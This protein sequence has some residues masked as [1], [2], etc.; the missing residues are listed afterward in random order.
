[1]KLCPD[2]KRTATGYFWLDW[3]TAPYWRWV[4]ART[5]RKFHR[6]MG[7]GDE[8]AGKRLVDEA[9]RDLTAQGSQE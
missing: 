5:E 7:D 9:L 2:F 6:F 3:I 4:V 1:M 8:A